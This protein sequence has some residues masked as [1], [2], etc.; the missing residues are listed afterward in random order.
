MPDEQQIEEVAAM[1]FGASL[2][3]TNMIGRKGWAW[4]ACDEKTKE[5]WRNIVQYAWNIFNR[6]ND[7][8]SPN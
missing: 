5:Y 7:I 2:A 8:L 3:F 4:D 6:P 1:L